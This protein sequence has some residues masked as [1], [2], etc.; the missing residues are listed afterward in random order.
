LESLISSAKEADKERLKKDLN[1]VDE[2]EEGGQIA[3]E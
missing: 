3:P 1:V 2:L